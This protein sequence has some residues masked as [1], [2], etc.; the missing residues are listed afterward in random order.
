MT[1]AQLAELVQG[2]LH[3][4]GS[5]V[6]KGARPLLEAGPADITFVENEKYARQLPRSKA[7]AAVV[8]QLVPSC[9]LAQ[10]ITPDPLAAFAVIV[11][12][13]RGHKD[14]RPARLDP[15]AAIHPT[16]RIGPG[17]TVLPFAFVGEGS[18]LGARCLIHSQVSIGRNCRIGDDVV[19]HPGVVLYDGTV[20][21]NRV[22]VHA[23]SVLGADGFGYRF[24]GGRHEKVPQLGHVEIGDDVEIGACSTIDRGTFESTQIGPGTKIDNLVQVAHNCRIGQHNLLVSQVGIAGST[25][26]GDYVVIAGQVGVAE[27]LH[28][29]T[30]AVIGAR[31]GVMRDVPPGQRMLGAPATPEKEQ[32]RLVMTL[33]R[34]P[35]LARDIK[36]IKQHLHLD[37]PETQAG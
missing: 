2:Q 18:V 9:A 8:H 22:I 11:Q 16:A 23:N 4:D 7:A 19:L 26:T 32:K 33:A 29:G 6:I 25:T 3:G 15:R 17:C 13:L 30:G 12:H 10:I 24:Q 37:E 27:H 21:G 14:K 1:L 36:R 35:E 28:I 31:A 20:L 34:L 5:L